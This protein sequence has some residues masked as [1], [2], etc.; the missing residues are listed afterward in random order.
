MFSINVSLFAL[1]G[2]HCCRN[3][4]CF[5]G[6]TLF[7]EQIEKHF[8][9]INMLSRVSQPR[10]QGFLGACEFPSFTKSHVSTMRNIVI[11]IAIIFKPN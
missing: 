6:S 9:G 1:L 8:D 10:S 7:P 3:K 4:I 2:K 11:H 5:P